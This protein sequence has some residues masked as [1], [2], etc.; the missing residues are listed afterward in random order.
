MG[1]PY[2]TVVYGHTL[3]TGGD[4]SQAA[5]V[6]GNTGDANEIDTGTTFDF[7]FSQ[8][9]S[10]TNLPT[11]TACTNGTGTNANG[12]NSLYLGMSGSGADSCDI[13]S[14][15]LSGFQI[16]M[17][18]NPT[19][20]RV[21]R[22]EMTVTPTDPCADASS[23]YTAPTE[24]YCRIRITIGNRVAG[25]TANDQVNASGTALT[26]RG[27]SNSASLRSAA[28][29]DFCQAGG[30]T[31]INTSDATDPIQRYRTNPSSGM[32]VFTM[33]SVSF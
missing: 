7:T 6:I 24:G 30:T 19:T 12:G 21:R 27:T 9:I 11:G 31:K 3:T 14:E 8:P 17:T 29:R 32:C 18:S 2:E 15:T 25:S 10:T 1:Y 4:P 13:L 28:G 33:A 26:I 16:R 20:A 23:I 22:Y 5:V